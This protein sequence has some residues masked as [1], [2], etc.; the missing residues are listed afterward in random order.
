MARKS[1]RRRPRLQLH[2]RRLGR[3]H[4]HLSRRGYLDTPISARHREH[5]PQWHVPPMAVSRSRWG[6]GTDAQVHQQH[7][8][9]RRD[10][11]RIRHP[12]RQ[13]CRMGSRCLRAH[14]LQ[15]RKVMER[16][17]FSRP[18]TAAR[19]WIVLQAL[20]SPV[21]R[22]FERSPGSRIDSSPV[23]G[24]SRCVLPRTAPKASPQIRPQTEEISSDGPR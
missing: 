7:R 20:A 19:R 6:I 13:R 24:I 2:H 15:Q 18:P 5:C 12:H 23:A 16:A 11:L 21:G 1:P 22:T 4:L 10:D 8:L 17:E 14:S 3:P 9:E